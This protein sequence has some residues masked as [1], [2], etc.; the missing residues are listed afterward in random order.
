V[1]SLSNTLLENKAS[2]T[3][4][5]PKYYNYI[6]VKEIPFLFHDAKITFFAFTLDIEM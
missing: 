2:Y 1:S 4:G 5:T 3:S 6:K